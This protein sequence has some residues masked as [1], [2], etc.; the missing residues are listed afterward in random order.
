MKE[1]YIFSIVFV[2]IALAFIAANYLFHRILQDQKNALLKIASV[3]IGMILAIAVLVLFVPGLADSQREKILGLLGLLISGAFALSSTTFLGNALAGMMIRT[4]G[5]VKPGD[6][7]K[8]N[9]YF[10]QVSE[11]GPFHVKIQIE[12]RGTTTLPNLYLTTNPVEVMREKGTVISTDVSLGYDVSR[13]K[14][15][16]CLEKAAKE[17]EFVLPPFFVHVINLGDFSVVYRVM[18]ILKETDKLLSARS[19]LNEAVLD[20]LHEAGIEIV[21]PAFMNQRQVNDTIFIPKKERVKKE[22]APRQYLE[23]ITFDDA[24]H[25]GSLEKKKEV[26]ENLKNNL[27]E[28][29]KELS[30]NTDPERTQTLNARLSKIKNYIDALKMDI[31]EETK[32][33]N[34]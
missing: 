28:I 9:D 4:T 1:V 14:I 5:S 6:F 22:E 17:A 34:S 27:I 26:L 23:D 33:A 32:S 8:V 24:K 3:F 20:A 29:E 13:Q 12:N 19:N 2:A 31:E 7:I 16:Q 18:G 10:G 21:S 30:T 15:K 11:Q 25:A